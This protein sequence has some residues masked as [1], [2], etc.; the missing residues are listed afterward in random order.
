MNDAVGEYERLGLGLPKTFSLG[1]WNG[2]RA[3]IV[4]W[5]VSAS[6][7]VANIVI[8]VTDKT[9]YVGPS[10]VE[11][12]EEMLRRYWRCECRRNPACSWPDPTTHKM[13]RP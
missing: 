3:Q 4:G 5:K 7:W 2:L 10:Q 12:S 9:R 8:G 11:A 13:Q 1:K 6:G